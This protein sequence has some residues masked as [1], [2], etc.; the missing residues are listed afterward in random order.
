HGPSV[1]TH[2]MSNS[3]GRGLPSAPGNQGTEDR[4]PNARTIQR[5]AWVL[6][7]SQHIAMT[8]RPDPP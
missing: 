7:T 4:F 3:V 1:P 2:R 6:A 5:V 8:E